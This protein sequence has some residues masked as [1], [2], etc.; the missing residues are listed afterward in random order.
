MLLHGGG[1]RKDR[2]K[3]L[4]DLSLVPNNESLIVVATGSYI[5]E[6][7]DQ[8]RFDTLLLAA[9]VSFEGTLSQYVGRLHRENDGKTEAR[10][11]DYIDMAVPLSAVMYRKRLRAYS[12]QG[13]SVNPDHTEKTAMLSAK[14]EALRAR[15]TA[16]TRDNDAADA[17]L[18]TPS[19]GSF[20]G[21]IVMATN[22]AET[23]RKD[24][25]SCTRSLIISAEYVSQQG[26]STIDDE[27]LRLS[28]RKSHIEVYV[29]LPATAAAATRTR[30][31][32][33]INRLRAI[34]C[35]VRTVESCSDFA[36]IDDGLVWF[37]CIPL[38]GSPR[39][40]DCS[41]RFI[42]TKI[43]ENLA[44]GLKQRQSG[45]FNQDNRAAR[46]RD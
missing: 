28:D 41:L 15:M 19:D 18:D 16:A 13:Y 5:G 38:L 24:I 27:L 44:A 8:K 35:I 14:A 9:P 17:V 34:G 39:S 36:I 32:R 29:R 22:Y 12:N 43:G 3:K 10:V 40:D 37:G 23:L 31:E 1:S 30:I 21:S 42:D 45:F 46:G 11:Y 33:N 20:E 7:F 26:L 6:G 25:A 2:Q 4:H